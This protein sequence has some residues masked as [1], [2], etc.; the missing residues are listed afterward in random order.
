MKYYIIQYTNKKPELV[1]AY[2]MSEAITQARGIIAR[3][4]LIA[5]AQAVA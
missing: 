1:K 4:D 2:T 3:V 5:Y